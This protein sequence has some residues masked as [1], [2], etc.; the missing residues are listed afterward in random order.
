SVKIELANV[1]GQVVASKTVGLAPGQD[2]FEARV[3]ADGIPLK[4]AATAKATLLDAAGKV[5][6]VAANPL[7]PVPADDWVGVRP[8]IVTEPMPPWQP[9]IAQV[10]NGEAEIA[11]FKHKLHFR[12]SLL[13]DSISSFG[14]ALS[15]A[16]WYFLVE[17]DGRQLPLKTTAPIRLAAEDARG[18]TL[19]WSGEN[20]L[21]S[22]AGTVRVEFD[23]LAWVEIE[24][25][26]RQPA[27][28]IGRF[29]IATSFKAG[30]MRY[31]SAA[32]AMQAM[33]GATATALIGA[34][35][36]DRA[37]PPI[38][39]TAP[40]PFSARGWHWDKQ[41]F[42]YIRVAGEDRAVY[43]V[44]PSK[45]NV[46]V[47]GDYLAV[48]DGE[49]AFGLQ[50]NLI[51]GGLKLSA[52]RRYR[53]GFIVTPSHAVNGRSRLRRL[54]AYFSKPTWNKDYTRNRLL[55]EAVYEKYGPRFMHPARFEP[56]PKG[57]F[58]CPMLPC[59]T[60][61]DCQS[62]NPRPDA[63]NRTEIDNHVRGIRASIGGMPTLWFDSLITT[64]NRMAEIA[65]YI[66]D[67]ER[68]PINRLPIETPATFVC[69]KG[70]WPDY[71]LSGIQQRLAQGVECFYWD[72]TNMTG[73]TNRFHGC[74]WRD[75]TGE[76]FPTIPFLETREFVLRAQKLLKDNNPDSVIMLHGGASTP[77]ALWCDATL[78]GEG[79]STAPDYSGL[80]P[81]L[82]QAEYMFTR[83]SGVASVHFAGL[84]YFQ[85]PNFHRA[86]TT[87]Q[88][89][90]G[91]A[92][93]H[94]EAVWNA[95][96]VEI[97]G[98]MMV[99]KAVNEFGIDHP[100]TTWTPYWRSRLSARQ[101]K[102][103]KISSYARARKR[104]LVVFNYAYEPRRVD[105]SGLSHLV[106]AFTGETVP[107]VFE[108]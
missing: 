68:Y 48:A 82:F 72:M 62:G 27:T 32:N 44:Q 71:Y 75:G 35:R 28:Q 29:A 64:T 18:V 78:K 15:A 54:G 76:V 9:L 51:E 107:T 19:S 1:A 13:P 105:L 95:N 70:C 96:P 50:F 103:V 58:T 81:E 26:P 12:D 98:N 49:K 30:G 14:E 43:F 57:L 61:K 3:A 23:G 69:A 59:W 42:N 17:V 65:P 20:E 77:L 83:S 90:W 60:I 5:L 10:G 25:R 36:T 53:F 52:P 4:E 89:V 33:K 102:E 79:W 11:I 63:A 45:Q 74:G 73:C 2:W 34:A 7:D 106:D 80:S 92:L 85:Y 86:S 100:E 22:V 40:I 16:P 84:L 94:D 87:Q 97:P 56:A 99:W 67:F 24:L 41:F 8:G 108:L 55:D 6:Q 101:T 104:L 21:V 91:M 39:T 46:D 31:M 88:E 38:N 47:K 66:K 93:L 37:I